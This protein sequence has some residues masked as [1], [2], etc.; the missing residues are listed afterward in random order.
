MPLE[1]RIYD[2]GVIPSQGMRTLRQKI[3]RFAFD[4]LTTIRAD[5]R[6]QLNKSDLAELKAGIDLQDPHYSKWDLTRIG[7]KV[8]P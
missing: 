3:K 1:R 2:E 7:Q 5:Y 6:V 8:K 4:P